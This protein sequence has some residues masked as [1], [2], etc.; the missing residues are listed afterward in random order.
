M[1]ISKIVKLIFFFLIIKSV[2][3]CKEIT[4]KEDKIITGNSI[5]LSETKEENTHQSKEYSQ[6]KSINYD[7]KQ[8]VNEAVNK[9]K[10]F[11]LSCY[12]YEG[13]RKDEDNLWKKFTT[14]RF[15]QKTKELNSEDNYVLDY[16]PFIYGQDYYREVIRKTLKIKV[17]PNKKNEFEVSLNHFELENEKPT[18]VILYLVKEGDTYLIDAINSD[19][20]LNLEQINKFSEKYQNIKEEEKKNQT[21][22]KADNRNYQIEDYIGSYSYFYDMGKLDEIASMTIDYSF[23]IKKNDIS[24]SGQGYKTNFDDLCEAKINNGVLEI[25]YKETIEGNTYNS[26]RTQPLFKIYKKGN[27]FYAISSFIKD[28]KEIKLKGD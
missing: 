4:K 24:F 27:D 1:G 21:I 10:E 22:A 16:D 15:Y 9:I 17:I 7:K 6:D 13:E 14:N 5:V 20:L 25:Y 11:Y 12:G 2:I 3:S 18:K 19:K 28:G 23:D 26:N 8:N